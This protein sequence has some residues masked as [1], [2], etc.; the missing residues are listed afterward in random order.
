M[1]I[2]Y[3]SPIW[4][5]AFHGVEGQAV[6]CPPPGRRSLYSPGGRTFPFYFLSPFGN[7]FLLASLNSLY[8]LYSLYSV[9]SIYSLYS[10]SAYIEKAYSKMESDAPWRSFLEPQIWPRTNSRNNWITYGWQHTALKISPQIFL[11][12]AMKR[13][14][15]MEFGRRPQTKLI[16]ISFPSSLF[17]TLHTFIFKISIHIVQVVQI[18]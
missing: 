8:T 6:N 9:Y 2:T 15:N 17:S 11:E 10:I 16:K 4:A 12:I 1:G 18:L 7:W 13:T 5:R 14:L 3:P